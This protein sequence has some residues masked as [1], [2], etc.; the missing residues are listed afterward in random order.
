M[1]VK[2]FHFCHADGGLILNALYGF[3]GFIGFI[4]VILLPL[5]QC[6]ELSQIRPAFFRKTLTQLSWS[7]WGFRKTHT[8]DVHLSS[9][10]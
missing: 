8:V 9:Y 7:H 4:G 5:A 1:A 3:I 2:N 10:S 6:V